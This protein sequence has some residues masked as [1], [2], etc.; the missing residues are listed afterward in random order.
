MRLIGAGNY[1]GATR[2]VGSIFDETIALS[3]KDYSTFKLKKGDVIL[4]GGGEDISPSLYGQKPIMQTSANE[5]LSPRDHYEKILFERA[6]EENLAT[7]G[8]CRGAQLICALSKGSLYQHVVGHSTGEHK[9]KTKEGTVLSVSSAHHQMM[10]P[11]GTKHE[12]LAWACSSHDHSDS[13]IS[14]VHLIEKE[15]NIAVDK[16][17]EAIYFNDTKGLALQ[18]HPEFMPINSEGVKYSFNLIK[19]LLF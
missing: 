2:V 19:E 13:P 1:F 16:E 5:V 18:W 9:I 6:L 4:F 7:I 3:N 17:P 12:L 8:I 10:N 15:K 11:L 14:R